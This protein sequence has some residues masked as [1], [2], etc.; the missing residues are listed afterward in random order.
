MSSP[1]AHC[2]DAVHWLRENKLPTAGLTG[3]DARALAAIAHAWSLYSYT[4]EARVL[5]AIKLLLAT[6][7]QK[8]RF[9]ARELIAHSMDWSNRKELW[10]LVAPD[11]LDAVSVGKYPQARYSPEGLDAAERVEMRG[12]R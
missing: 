7:Q 12:R 5:D 11:T 1:K 8:E 9:L 6:M 3:T 10:P 4:R 2:A